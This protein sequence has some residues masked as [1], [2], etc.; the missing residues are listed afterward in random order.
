MT[1]VNAMAPSS[2]LDGLTVFQKW[3]R[4]RIDRI[5]ISWVT[6]REKIQVSLADGG[7]LAVQC[8]EE[9]QFDESRQGDFRCYRR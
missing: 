5:T 9:R 7:R 8:E 2:G 6:D 3:S 4:L 1:A